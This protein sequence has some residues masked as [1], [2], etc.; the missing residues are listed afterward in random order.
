M[1]KEAG[2][3]VMDHIN[4][5]MSDN[6]VLANIV[7]NNEET[8]KKEVMADSIILNEVKGYAK[9]WKINSEDVKMG[10]EKI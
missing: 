8:I 1:R 7:K 10:V 5:Y 4:V 6:E 2:F 3:E 9:D